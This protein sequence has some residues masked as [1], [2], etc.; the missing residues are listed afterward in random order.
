MLL[1][2]GKDVISLKRSKSFDRKVKSKVYIHVVLN[3]ELNNDF[4]NL[5]FSIVTF[6][7]VTSDI[8]FSSYPIQNFQRYFYRS[9]WL[10]V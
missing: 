5:N 9:L 7:C 1:T 6:K 4:S 8:N 10:F 2:H 3:A